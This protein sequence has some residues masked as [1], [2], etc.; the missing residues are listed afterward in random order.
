MFHNS[1]AVDHNLRPGFVEDACDFLST[2]RR[3]LVRLAL[4]ASIPPPQQRCIETTIKY[5]YA[6][7]YQ[8]D[9]P[10][11]TLVCLALEARGSRSQ[12]VISR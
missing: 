12:S 9:I 5:I 10:W 11:D 3:A 4:E 6:D 7:S 2:P 8:R 1:D